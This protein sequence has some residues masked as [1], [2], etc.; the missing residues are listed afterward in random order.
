LLRTRNK[1]MRPAVARKKIVENAMKATMTTTE[2]NG[3]AST[4]ASVGTTTATG[5]SNDETIEE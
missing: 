2:S 3:T 4:T 1:L 5:E